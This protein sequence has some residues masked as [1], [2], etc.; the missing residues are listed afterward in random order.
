M[1]QPYEL[2]LTGVRV[3]DHPVGTHIVDAAQAAAP[4]GR[5]MFRVAIMPVPIMLSMPAG[6][7]PD[8]GT[9]AVLATGCA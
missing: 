6:Q 8:H 1:G 2:A 3:G 4:T 5:G 9:T 7:L